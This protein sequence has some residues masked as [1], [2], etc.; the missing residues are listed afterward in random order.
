MRKPKTAAQLIQSPL[1]ATH[2]LNRL[3]KTIER[4]PGTRKPTPTR[5]FSS[6]TRKR[7]ST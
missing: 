2:K 1:A 3:S 6:T 4:L 7:Q 5:D